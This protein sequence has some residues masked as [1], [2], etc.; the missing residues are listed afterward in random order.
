MLGM[1]LLMGIIRPCLRKYL[2]SEKAK[3]VADSACP[4]VRN[5]TTE[6]S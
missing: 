5:F 6:L 2:A 3:L 1:T 4:A